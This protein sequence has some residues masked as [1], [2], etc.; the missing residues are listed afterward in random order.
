MT[1]ELS[2]VQLIVAL[3]TFAKNETR[4]TADLVR[5]EPSLQGITAVPNVGYPGLAPS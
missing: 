5:I 3:K 2:G 1:E 4:P